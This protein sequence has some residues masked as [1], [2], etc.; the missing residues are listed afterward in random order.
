ME[1]LTFS[2]LRIGVRAFLIPNGGTVF[3]H[4]GRIEETEKKGRRAF[5]TEF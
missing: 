5:N 2:L 4:I 3:I 1:L